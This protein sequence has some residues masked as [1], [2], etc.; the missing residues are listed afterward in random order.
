MKQRSCGYLILPLLLCL[1]ACPSPPKSRPDSAARTTPAA[2]KKGA[3][4]DVPHEG[5]LA[6]KVLY[7]R[8]KSLLRAGKQKLAVTSFNKAIAAD[9]KGD[10]LANCYL[11]LGSTLGELE[12]RAE[13]LKAYEKVV[14]LRP[15]D[16]EAYRALA[17]GQED[18]AQISNAIQSLEQALALDA[19]QLVAYQDLASLHLQQKKLDAAKKVYLRY[20]FRRTALIRTLGL[21]KDEQR[22]VYAATALGEARDEATCKALGLALTSS[23]KKVRL[24]V[25]M[26]LGRQ[27]LAMGAG[28]LRSLLLK[29]TDPLERRQI[30]ASLN[31]ILNAPQPT[32][33]ASAPAAS[34][35]SAPA[36]APAKVKP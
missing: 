1:A 10:L 27:G 24:A 33:P 26:A 31:A 14:E 12:R 23:S 11:G 29:T 5:P 30:Q 3:H 4:P 25:I 32:A 2:Q 35:A 34:P 20:E 19:D 21:A 28:P 16:P 15:D 17:I 36:S 18:A 7:E 8:A 22:R 6:Q 9:P 13:A